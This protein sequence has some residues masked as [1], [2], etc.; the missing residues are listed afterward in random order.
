[1]EIK[2][3]L[4]VFAA[5]I[6]F[7]SC[8]K[9]E[10]YYYAQYTADDITID[11][12]ADESAW[13]KAKWYPINQLYIGQEQADYSGRFK[14]LWKNSVLFLFVEITDNILTNSIADGFENYWQ[15][16]CIEIFIDESNSKQDHYQNNNAFAYHILHTGEVIDIDADGQG[17]I[18]PDTANFKVL[19]SG[20]K[21]TW[22]IALTVYDNTYNP[23]SNLHEKS[24]VKLT[25]GKKLG[26]TVAY[27]DNDGDG[28]E[29]FH[30]S[31]PNQGD[32]GYITSEKFATLELVK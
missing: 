11:G 5:V 15:G 29:S 20:E 7:Q 26:F 19:K 4:I 9:A 10:S 3:F 25:A 14:I 24:K 22:E 28:R 8:G 16:D 18:F 6:V 32:S 17:K 2:K 30:G 13:Q 1:M 21:Y 27:G 31:T 12:Q 23:N